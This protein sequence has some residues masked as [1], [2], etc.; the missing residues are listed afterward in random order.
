[1][2]GRRQPHDIFVGTSEMASLCRAF[3]WAATSLG[4][5]EGWSHSLRTTVST[6]L[7]S[8]HPMFLWW[9][10]ELVQI[11]NDAYR[12]S[13]AEGGR[14]PRA[15]G[16]RGAEFWTEIW[17]IIGPQIEGVMTRGEATW[18]EDQL[19]PIER[20]GRIEEVYWTYG[21]SPVFDDDG[22]IGGT[23]VVC[24]ETT[25]RVLATAERDRLIE[26][27]RRARA[28]ADAARDEMAHVFAQA[29]VAIAVLQGREFRYT[30]ANPKYQQLIGNRDP[31]GKRLVEMFPDLAG[32]E[33][34]RV[35]E[36]VYDTAVPFAATD[37]LARFDSQGRGEVD[38]YYD[39]VYHPLVTQTG[40]VN[41]I[42]AVAV[43]VT[44][45][46][47]VSVERERLLHMSK[48]ALAEA[49]KAN[50]AK[51][52]FLAVMSHELRTPLNAIG[53]YVEL[54]EL[55]IR[56]P[57]T[58]EQQADLTRIQTS[59]RH[60]LGLINAVLNYTRVEAGMID[61]A[62]T[63]VRLDEILTTCEMLTAP[64]MGARGLH[65]DY[66]TGDPQIMAYADPEKLQQI[67]LNL[68]TNAIKFTDPGGTITLACT[69]ADET[70]Y[71]TV[72]D[73]GR[74]IAP[75]QL[76]RV[77]EPFVQVD[78]RLTRTNDGVGLGLAISRDLARG[79]G[80]NLTAQSVLGVGSTFTV[81]LPRRE[82]LRSRSTN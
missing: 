35:L 51:M 12:P 24:T 79:M 72:T 34:E 6:L 36:Q 3:D 81:Q 10:P 41:G 69:V 48:D 64:Q 27:E 31:T 50:R 59:Q 33:V 5:V 68:L 80:G 19:V 9:G 40:T 15:L 58:P 71:V 2:H 82:T 32:S 66:V 76:A 63:D 39:L 8:R 44:G 43:D 53:G 70:V 77:F 74:G 7:A 22:S 75:D 4:P 16:M 37:F 57:I 20:N 13:F 73:T 42:V 14:H 46:R 21:Y 18:H 29:P 23:L 67:V 52:E 62:L 61:Y 25:Q 1:M 55:G 26:A 30:V 78:V 28:D 38:N 65:F 45:R 56:G 11:Y 54:L 49:E 17:D 60:L 47:N